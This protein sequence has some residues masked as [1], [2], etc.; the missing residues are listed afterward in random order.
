VTKYARASE[1][2]N[3]LEVRGCTI[4][5]EVDAHKMA[6][7][8]LLRYRKFDMIIYNFPHADFYGREDNGFQIE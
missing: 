6:E 1:K 3:E 7:H 2:L 8:P 4:V 5:N